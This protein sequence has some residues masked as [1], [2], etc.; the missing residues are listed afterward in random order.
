MS[1]PASQKVALLFPGQGSHSV[2]MGRDLYEG[3]AAAR[4]VFE[5]VD[6]ALGRPLSDIIFAGP[7]EELRRTDNAQPAIAAVSLAC[8]R[9]M[10]EQD[11]P[12]PGVSMVAGHSLGEYTA[13][14]ATGV[15]SISDTARLVVE[16][17]RLMQHACEERPGGMAALV[18]I[19]ELVVEDVCRQTGTYISNINTPEQIVISGDHMNLARA[20]DLAAARGARRCIP[21]KVG[22]A[23]HSGLMAPARS[24][25]ASVIDSLEFHD[26]LVPIVANVNAQP[27]RTGTEVK[28]ELTTQLLSCVQW[29]RTVRFM[30]EQGIDRFIEIGP[31]RVLA[32]LVQRNEPGVAVTNV[33][34]LASVRAL[35]A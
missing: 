8:M 32:S 5:E 11:G 17:G 2:G 15:L 25:L 34:D 35:A 19:D 12:A 26:P 28:K 14:A 6:E 4:Q 23:F 29:K 22:G 10:E 24:G 27:L 30:L 20:I 16:R 1:M 3:S 33:S 21:L 7:E 13:L 18:G 9:A 31:G